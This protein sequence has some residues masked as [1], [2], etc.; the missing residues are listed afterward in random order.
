VALAYGVGYML[1]LRTMRCSLDAQHC[2]F[3]TWRRFIAGIAVVARAGRQP[4]GN[5]QPDGQLQ[6]GQVLADDFDVGRSAER[7]G[8]GTELKRLRIADGK[9]TNWPK[10]RSKCNLCRDIVK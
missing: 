1:S 7:A 10:T 2:T 6:S 8:Y 3:N 4:P 9:P 5:R